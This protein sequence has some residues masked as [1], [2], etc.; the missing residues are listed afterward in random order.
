MGEVSRKQCLFKRFLLG[1]ADRFSPVQQPVCIKRVVNAA[2]PAASFS[3][4]CKFKPQRRAAHADV[5]AVGVGLVNADAVFLRDVLGNF[6]ALG[7]HLW[8]QFKRLEVN[9]SCDFG[10]D[11][12]KRLVKRGKANHAPGARYVR[13]E[14]DF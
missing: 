5:L 9:F 1:Q 8:I 6:L 11:S 3:W 2:P 7:R 10:F 13:H 14:I 12:F 4:R